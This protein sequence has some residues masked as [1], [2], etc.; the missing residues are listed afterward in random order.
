ML[1]N[2]TQMQFCTLCNKLGLLETTVI[3]AR[4]TVGAELTRCVGRAF[5]FGEGSAYGTIKTARE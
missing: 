1:R 2:I 5:L 3:Q 4:A